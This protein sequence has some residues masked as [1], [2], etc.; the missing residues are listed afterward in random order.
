[1]LENKTRCREVTEQFKIRKVNAS[2]AVEKEYRVRIEYKDLQGF[3]YI[4][5]IMQGKYKVV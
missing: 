1:M 3:K 2:S 4:K 5:M